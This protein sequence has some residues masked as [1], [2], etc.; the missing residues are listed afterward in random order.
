MFLN[1]VIQVVMACCVEFRIYHKCVLAIIVVAYDKLRKGINL[2]AH[3]EFVHKSE[4]TFLF[5]Y[6]VCVGVHRT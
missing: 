2:K 1:L 6:V 4:Y 3:Q 5:F